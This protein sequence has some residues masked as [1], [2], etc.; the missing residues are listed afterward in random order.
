MFSFMRNR[1][2]IPGVISVIALVF[3]MVGGA[4]AAKKYVISSTSQ[5][6]PSVLKSLK[7]AAG[8]PGAKGDLGAPGA[9]GA[10][11]DP[12]AAGSNGKDGNSITSNSFAGAEGGCTE[13]GSKF[14]A[15]A[16]TT[17]ACNGKKGAEGKPGP[18]CP[19]DACFLPEKATETGTW[20]TSIASPA[21]RKSFEISFSLPLSEAPAPILVNST[22]Q[23]KPGCPG[24]GGGEF[25]PGKPG[26][27]PTVP[28]AD[29]GKLCVY[30]MAIENAVFVN[31][32]FATS[33][34]EEA[35]EEWELVSGASQSGTLLNVNCTGS[36]FA[37]GSWAVTGPE[38]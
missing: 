6:K 28:M 14:V 9:P 25:G 23:S 3:A 15:G 19:V 7:G 17:F 36:C 4:Y 33:E 24:R 18:A 37:A 8:A 30:V 11:G 29:P 26:N 31:P 10:K 2:G 34:F 20:G 38:E 5:I 13:G 27:K 16:S 22:E 1:F 32:I 21:G 12:G 35:F